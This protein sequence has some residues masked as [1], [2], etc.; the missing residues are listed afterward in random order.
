MAWSDRR[1]VYEPAW[2]PRHPQNGLYAVIGATVGFHVLKVLLG[3]LQVIEPTSSRGSGFVEAWFGMSVNGVARGRIWQPLTYIF[4]HGG[5]VHLFWNMLILFF[6]GRLLEGIVGLRRFVFLYLL[7]GIGG[8]LGAFLTGEPA[9]PIIGASGSVM[10][11]LAVLMVLAPDH[12][13]NAILFVIRL[14]WIV[15]VLVVMDICLALGDGALIEQAP[16]TARWTH[17]LGALTGF[18]AAWLWPRVVRPRLR[19]ARVKAR[20]R[21]EI[22]AAAARRTEE[23]ELDRILEKINRQGLASLD[24]RE[25][26]VLQRASSR[27][28]NSRRE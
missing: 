12:P 25:R 7:C 21:K 15:L 19:A 6:A 2:V 1:H 26:A 20:H 3:A 14:K 13:V 16:T 28:Q 5:V 4:V 11:I 18:G 9:R 24:A 8:A 22:E 27:Y 17:V 10:G 23:E